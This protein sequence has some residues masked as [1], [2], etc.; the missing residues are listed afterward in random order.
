MLRNLKLPVYKYTFDKVVRHYDI[1]CHRY[2]EYMAT[3]NAMDVIKVFDEI[4]PELEITNAKKIDFALWSIRQY[5]I[6]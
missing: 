4:Y 5:E 3:E 2:A 6:I 1:L